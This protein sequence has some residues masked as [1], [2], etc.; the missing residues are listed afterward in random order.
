MGTSRGIGGQNMVTLGQDQQHALSLADR[1]EAEEG[2]FFLSGIQALVRVLLDRRRRD[3]AAGLNTAAFVC[4]YPGS[5]LGGFDRELERQGALLA[6]LGVVHRPGLNEDLA[7]T[8]VMGSQVASTFEQAQVDGVLGIWY[9]KAP[10]LDRAVDAMRHAVYAGASPLGGAVVLVGDDPA[11]KSSTLPSASERVL[12]E[13][14]IPVFFPGTMQEILDY[15]VH[16][17]EMSRRSGLWT[18]LKMVTPVADG[19]GTADVSRHR[20]EVAESRRTHADRVSGRQLSPPESNEIERELGDWLDVA[21]DYGVKNHLN[22]IVVDPPHPWLAIVAGGFTYHQTVEALSSLGLGLGDLYDNGIRLV[23]IGL[24]YPLDRDDI[25]SWGEQA[26]EMLVVEEKRPFLEHAIKEALYGMAGCPRVVGKLDDDGTELI[27][28]WGTLESRRL[29]DPLR[30]VLRRRLPEDALPPVV[31]AEVVT[32]L[33]APSESRSAFFCSGC[34]HT[35]S[36]KVPDG[37]SVGAGIGCH[38]MVKVLPAKR[39]GDIVT[40]TQMG[41]EGAQWAGIEPFVAP[42]PFVQNLGDGTLMHSGYLAIRF[43]VAAQLHMTYKILYNSAIAMTGGQSPVG[44]MGVPDL[45]RTL[46]AEGVAA[47]IITTED[48]GRYRGVNLPAGVKV[49]DRADMIAAQEQLAA[50]P[51]VTILIHD[52]ACAAELRRQ[53]KTGEA[54]TPDHRLV[55]NTSV[56]EGCG[57]CGEK[58]ACLSLQPVMTE[59]GRKTAI[60]QTSCN[61]DFSCL[62]GDCPSF[63]EVRPKKRGSGTRPTRP[64]P[65]AVPVELPEPV[66]VVG[67]ELVSIRMPGIGGTGVVTVAQIL[68]VAAGLDGKQVAGVDQTG[69]SQKAGPVVSEL[70][71]SIGDETADAATDIDV[72]L[73]LDL[74]VAVAP[75]NLAGLRADRTVVVGST[76]TTQ[77]GAMVVDSRLP[78]PDTSAMQAEIERRTKPGSSCWVDA[79]GATQALFGDTTTANVFVL[80]AAYQHGVLPVRADAIEEAIVLNGTAVATNQ[81]AFRWGRCAVAAPEQLEALLTVRGGAGATLPAEVETDLVGRRF[82]P[83]LE[84]LVRTRAV[85]L[86]GYQGRSVVTRYLAGVDAAWRA[87]QAANPAST[88][89]TATVARNLHRVIAYKDEYEVARLLTSPGAIAQAEAVGGPGARVT[90]KLHP[91]MLRALGRQRKM[92]FGRWTRPVMQALRHGRVVRGTS[93]DPFGYAEVRRE[94]RR[95]INEYEA[96]CRRLGDELSATGLER[97]AEVAALVG[98]VRG[99]EGVKLRNLATYRAELAAALAP[100]S[101]L[102]TSSSITTS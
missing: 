52:Q 88:L 73:A 10:G 43:A 42:T 8:A 71:I 25:R 31:V 19:T 99:Y 69:V 6:D 66:L 100:A 62:Q 74:I 67:P 49:V 70:R 2:E 84:A 3:T 1:F 44:M 33:L 91:P 65:P 59:F 12:A 60:Q 83:T 16:A 41:G 14:S 28:G 13:M 32:P 39:V 57:D 40:V 79:F 94:E 22:Q 34:P 21:R 51:G 61:F 58:S 46:T 77:T 29:T 27:P 48:T 101:V 68:G 54:P 37:F 5:P 4:G 30:R 72:L 81:A 24:L 26:Q 47:I 102:T 7:A 53:R 45:C 82:E 76:S 56:C 98:Q 17:V 63:M 85:D 23:K 18:A 9:G 55:I 64:T 92:S 35:T 11:S 96:L 86:M 97:A 93:L 87:E 50:L 90:W 20:V 80:G 78:Y 75:N 38:G 36:L 89:F 15:G 95:L